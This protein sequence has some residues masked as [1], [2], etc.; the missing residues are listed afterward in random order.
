MSLV[1]YF[2]PVGYDTRALLLIVE[3]KKKTEFEN[4]Y[5]CSSSDDRILSVDGP[6]NTANDL[7]FN[8]IRMSTESLCMV[9]FSLVMTTSLVKSSP[10][11]FAEGY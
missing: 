3:V 4:H 7:P 2:K 9:Q 5:S 10:I 8:T 1:F 6:Q 11:G